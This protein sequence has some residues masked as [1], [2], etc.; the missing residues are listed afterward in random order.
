MIRVRIIPTTT[1]ISLCLAHLA[2]HDYEFSPDS[3]CDVRCNLLISLV[4]EIYGRHAA[5]A[6]SLTS[7]ATASIVD[8]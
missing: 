2:I 1:A 5:P 3:T 8:Q 4:G 6:G 7:L